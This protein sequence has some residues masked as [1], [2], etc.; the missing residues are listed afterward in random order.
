MNRARSAV[1]TSATGPAAT[2]LPSRS[3]VYRL[4]TS[5]TSLSLWE[6]KTMA[7]FCFCSMR[8][9]SNTRS[10]SGSVREV[11]GSSMII[12]EASIIM[13]R[14]ISAICL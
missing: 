11:V 9:I 5:M 3:T 14:E 6:M 2:M 8:I 13:A 1:V 12:R 10:I 4:Q 7:T